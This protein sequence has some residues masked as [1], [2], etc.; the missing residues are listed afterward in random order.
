[1]DAERPSERRLVTC[2]FLDIVGSTE[3]TMALAPERMK[4]T[5]DQA[6]GEVRG[7]VAEHGGTIE[8][9]VGDAVFAL[10]GAPVT[11]ADDALRALRAAE[12]CRD[13]VSRG[14]VAV[15]IGVETGEAL[16]DLEAAE[17]ERQRMAVGRCVNIAARLQS[18]AEPGQILVGPTCYEAVAE[19]AELESR[20]TL[21]LKGIG[22][23]PTWRLV[24]AQAE[25]AATRTA[26]VGRHEELARLREAFARS[27]DGRATLALVSAPPGQG[28]TRLVREF[29]DELAGVRTLAA[30]CRPG[31]ETGSDTPLRQLLS[32]RGDATREAVERRV[33]GLFGEGDEARRVAGALVHSAGLGTTDLLPAHPIERQD[34]L[35]NAWRRYFAALG[36]GGPTVIWIDD[37]H[38]AEPEL[39][40]LIDRLTFAATVPLLVVGTARPEFGGSAAL[41]PGGDRVHIELS[42]L[43]EASARSLA[44]SIGGSDASGIERAEGNPLFIVELARSR[45]TSRGELPVNLRGAIAARLDELA[46]D[47]RELLQR[48]SVLGETFGVRE[49]ALLA[50]RD[51]STTAGALARLGHA[52]YLDPVGGDWRFHHALVHDVAYGRLP[53]AERMRLHAR[54]ARDGAHPE[55]AEALAHHWWEALRPPDAEWVWEGA[56]EV[57]RMR[58]D[59]FQAHLA[60]GQRHAERFAHEQA[61]EVY[62]R[63]L[64]LTAEPRDLGTVERAIANAYARNA[65]GDDAWE[66]RLRA[67]DAYRR[68]GTEPPAGLYAEMLAIP[69]YNWGFFRAP[70]PDELVLRLLDEGE[71]VARRSGDMPSLTRLLVQRSYFDGR[72][73]LAEEASRLVDGS[74]DPLPYADVLQRLA[75]V[76]VLTGE[77][78]RAERTYER[79]AELVR[80]GGRVDELEYLMFRSTAVLLLG[81]IARADELAAETL[82]ASAGTG[83]HLRSHALQTKEL[84]LVY[85]GDWSGV[86]EL[87]R[88]AVRLVEENPTTPWCMRGGYA[89]AAGAVACVLLGRRGDADPFLA[90]AVKMPWSSPARLNT[91]LLPAAMTGGEAPLPEEPAVV[92][93]WH[94]QLIDPARVHE[95][96]GLA[97]LERWPE[98]PPYLARL[99]AAAAKGARVAGAVAS[100][101][102]EEE[103]GGGRGHG[104]LRQLGC[105]GLSELIAFRPAARR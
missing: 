9:Y 42:G 48:A 45:T 90:A 54:Y 14:T 41:R 53:V 35:V 96:I 13:R 32:D 68:A 43:D 47:D 28:K 76:E 81:D 65:Q 104:A 86:A 2:L 71:G 12:S 39:V 37:L 4:R 89:V 78:A 22:G 60:A 46:P 24:R 77:F 85:R 97:M 51:L 19:T 92:R 75:M 93:P 88:E 70:P 1:M 8:K 52:A 79:V 38:W 66:H 34:E 67:I 26:F 61:V 95:P 50:G 99:D 80:S 105:H 103:A 59:A 58:Q 6:F 20:G 94:R 72:P 15:R 101:I 82:H 74:G 3:L 56:A 69:V 98:L 27:R 84:V 73:E 25:R 30:R 29:I 5:L 62:A 11:H 83:A 23:L 44:Q 100:A 33:A 21:E 31:S 18:A 57:D 64:Q 55:D 10:F 40:R 17:H 7:I 49:A 87:A 16:I 63:A 91:M 102:R 36:G